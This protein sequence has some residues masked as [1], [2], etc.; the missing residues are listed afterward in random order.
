[1]LGTRRN[2][3][4][5]ERR[6]TY[7]PIQGIDTPVRERTYMDADRVLI[8]G[9][10]GFIGSKLAQRFVETTDVVVVDNL[11]NGTR[12]NVPGKAVFVKGDLSE[13]ETYNELDSF[14][15]I[16]AVLH[17]AGQS[18]GE[19]SF[20][21][22]EFDFESHAES[23]FRL[24]RWCDSRD[25]YRLLYASSMSV[26]GATEY[27]PVDESNPVDPKTYYAAGKL[28]A[29]AYVKL[30]D[31][32]G[33]D[34]TVFRLFSV[35][36]PGQNLDNMKQGM[37]SIYL[38]F[39]LNEEQLVIKGPTDRFRDF[40]YVDDVVDIWGQAIDSEVTYGE[41][42]NLARGR[43]T[44]VEELVERILDACGR[45]EFPIEVTDGTPGD[46][47]GIYGDITKLERHLDRVPQTTLEKGLCE[48]VAFYDR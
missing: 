15:D 6:T 42:Y 14:D 7:R 21:K 5:L 30:F 26:Y 33:M 8:T 18:S 19:A 2:E 11:T 13:P 10:A 46:Q 48:M 34:N 29:E 17:L 25:I 16:D 20:Y 43:R 38:S 44:T 3:R 23:T 9:G 31:N 39:V 41:T 40:V 27:L 37:V 32:I 22:P 1:M 47:F 45:E 35:Y 36:G 12:D 28:A 4:L 24:L